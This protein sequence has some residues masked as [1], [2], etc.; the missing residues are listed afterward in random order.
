MA[1]AGE[2]LSTLSVIIVGCG[3][4]AGGFD[5]GQNYADQPYTHAGAYT[6]DKR[7]K[8]TACVDPNEARRSEFMNHWKI[9]IGF[10]SLKDAFIAGHHFDVISICSPSACHSHDLEVAIQMSPRLIFCEKPVTPLLSATSKL[11]AA[12][13]ASNILLAINHTRRWDLSICKL[14]GDIAS[15]RMGKLRS[16][17]GLYNK[18]ILNNGSHMIDLLHFLIGPLNIVKVGQPFTDYCSVDP[19]IP[20]LLESEQGIPIHIACAHAADYAVFELQ[21]VF[22]TGILTMMDG[23]LVWHKRRCVESDTFKGYLHLDKGSR[24]KGGYHKAMIRAVDNIYLAITSADVLLSTGDSALLA[25]SMCEKIK[26]IALAP[27]LVDIGT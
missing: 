8:V 5:E 7:F 11:V 24:S 18:G 14:A 26:R 3:N 1:Q 25:Q 19:T 10:E 16:I 2:V 9:Q 15:G 23:G 27:K 21:L 20:V 13:A 22:S 12:C 17:A 4:I 6:R